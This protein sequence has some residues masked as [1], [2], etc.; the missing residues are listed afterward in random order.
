MASNI[1]HNNNKTPDVRRMIAENESKKI[2]PDT[3]NNH[4]GNSF[5]HWFNFNLHYP[6]NTI[7]TII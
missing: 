1:D 4:T 2:F 6:W 7:Y 5:C 3:R